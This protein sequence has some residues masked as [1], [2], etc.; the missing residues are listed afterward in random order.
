MAWTPRLS[1]P[2]WQRRPLPKEGHQQGRDLAVRPDAGLRRESGPLLV[3]ETT[4]SRAVR[5]EQWTI[6]TVGVCC[7]SAP[8]PDVAGCPDE[9]QAPLRVA[10]KPPW[11]ASL[12]CPPVKGGQASYGIAWTV[13]PSS[14]HSKSAAAL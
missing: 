5:A 2:Q 6:E 14:A 7:V 8:K 11:F 9:F 1:V 13:V 4:S 3:H 10:R 12:T